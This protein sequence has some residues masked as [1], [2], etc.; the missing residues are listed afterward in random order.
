MLHNVFKLWILNVTT[1]LFVIPDCERIWNLCALEQQTSTESNISTFHIT[2]T[3]ITVTAKNP[4]YSIVLFKK[5]AVKDHE[6]FRVTRVQKIEYHNLY[7]YWL[8][9]FNRPDGKFFGLCRH[10]KNIW[11]KKSY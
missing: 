5:V 3:H 10:Q 4:I 8:E 11:T 6:I 1:S 9:T 2:F 7:K